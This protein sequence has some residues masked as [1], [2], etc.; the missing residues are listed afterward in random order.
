MPAR[1]QAALRV[2]LTAGV[3][4][5]PLITHVA[6]VAASWGAMAYALVL[7]QTA[8]GLWIVLARVPHPYKYVA[9]G[10]LAVCSLTLC[11]LHLKGGLVLSA[12]LPHALVYTG[13]LV[14]FGLSL[15]PGRVPVITALSHQIHGPLPARIDRYTRRVTQ[16]WCGFCAAELLGSALLLG[17]APLAWWSLFVNVLNGPC[18]VILLVGE[19][20]TR[21]LWVTNPPRERFGDMV[22]M[23]G[24]ISSK[25]A[26][27]GQG[28]LRA[29]ES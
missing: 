28:R 4:A 25:L 5:S 8:L 3:V 23:V 16:V 29:R 12:G 9:A 1:I 14:L 17:L 21:P 22:R 7:G 19:K 26:T 11:V 13:L 27:P 15:R 18:L 20:V 24:W 10:A 2:L 6:L